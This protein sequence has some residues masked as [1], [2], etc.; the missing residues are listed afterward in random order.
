MEQGSTLFLSQPP[1][2]EPLRVPGDSKEEERKIWTIRLSLMSH[3]PTDY[4]PGSA[5]GRTHHTYTE[6]I[7]HS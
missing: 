2:F 4:D 6:A 5:D 1:F 3:F 7:E